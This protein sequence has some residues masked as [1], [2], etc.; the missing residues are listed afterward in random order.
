MSNKHSAAARLL[1]G[2]SSGSAFAAPLTRR[3]ALRRSLAGAAGLWLA[4]QFALSALAASPPA[5]PR[6]N[7]KAKSVIQIWLWGGASHLDTFD[8]KP[9]AGN[10]YCGP[11]TSPIATNVAGI[12]I[13]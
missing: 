12:R 9:E 5:K 4:D 1:L 8:P 10:D 7:A 13:C 11:F 3:D 6:A 2:R